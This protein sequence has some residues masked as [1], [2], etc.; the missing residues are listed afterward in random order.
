MAKGCEAHLLCVLADHDELA[1]VRLV[2]HHRLLARR[3]RLDRDIVVRLSV[4]VPV[5]RPPPTPPPPRDMSRMTRQD[6]HIAPDSCIQNSTD[7]AYNASCTQCRNTQFSTTHRRPAKGALA[8]DE[9]AI[10]IDLVGG[11]PVEPFPVVRENTGV[12]ARGREPSR[13]LPACH[14][15][16][17]CMCVRVCGCEGP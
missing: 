4:G 2:Q 11:M 16:G 17:R 13:A 6:T 5:R 15:A 7:T 10:G 8:V 12:C 9:V 3:L 1:K 14:G